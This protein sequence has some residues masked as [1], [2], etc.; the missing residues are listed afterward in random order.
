[1]KNKFKM[2][3]IAA[4]LIT[5]PSFILATAPKQDN[6]KQKRKADIELQKEKA[7]ETGETVYFAQAKPIESRLFKEIVKINYFEGNINESKVMET[8]RIKNKSFDAVIYS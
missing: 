8:L 4:C 6:E 1:M 2:L 7:N 3:L 5:A